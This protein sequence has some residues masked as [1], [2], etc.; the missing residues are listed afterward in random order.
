MY[1]CEDNG[2]CF[3]Y[4][5][6]NKH[7]RNLRITF[8]DEF[9]NVVYDIPDYTA[10]IQFEK[11]DRDNDEMIVSLNTISGFLKQ[12]NIYFLIVLEYLKII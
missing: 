12:I 2:D 7:V 11:Y 4:K 5:I 1:Q 8:T 3:N 10:I 9:E 6:F